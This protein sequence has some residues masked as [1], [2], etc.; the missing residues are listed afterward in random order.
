MQGITL[1]RYIDFT[2]PGLLTRIGFV[3]FPGERIVFR[4]AGKGMTIWAVPD[5]LTVE[6]LFFVVVLR[7]VVVIFFSLL[8]QSPG[9]TGCLSASAVF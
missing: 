5:F 1:N 3:S 4:F 2:F 6:A 9:A 7:V 8:K